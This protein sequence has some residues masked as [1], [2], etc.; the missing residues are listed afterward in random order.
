MNKPLVSV[1]MPAYNQVGFV[2]EALQS[3]V[4]QDYP[5]LQVVAGDDGSIDGTADIIS[6]YAHR[7]PDRVIPIVGK[8]HVGLTPNCN[9]TLKACTGKYIALFAGDDMFLP[10]KI[11]PQVAWLE[12]DERRVICGHDVEAFDSDTGRRLWLNS[13]QFP[14]RVGYGAW[15]VVRYSPLYSGMS[16]MVRAS[17]LPSWGFDERL[18]FVSDWKLQIDCLAAGGGYGYIEGLYGRYR[19][20]S[21]N[22]S[23][24]PSFPPYL[25]DKFKLL[26]IVET[27]YPHLE[28]ACH[29]HRAILLQKLGS[30][31][32]RCGDRMGARQHLRRSLAQYPWLSWKVPIKLAL[33]YLP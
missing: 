5:N 17:A 25:D 19:R 13:E 3:A 14:F 32:L 16:L 23:A 26:D 8:P 28:S 4:D 33:S 31:L 21:R 30:K 27:T 10:G 18:S 24:D 12:A 22:V 20:H 29:I 7:Y 6:D 2:A 1:F 11:T 15:A 9:R